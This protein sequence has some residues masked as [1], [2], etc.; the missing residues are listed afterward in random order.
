MNDADRAMIARLDSASPAEIL[1]NPELQEQVHALLRS[2]NERMQEA[3]RQLGIYRD[4]LAR[5][6]VAR[7]I[8]SR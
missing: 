8:D 3:T 2:L 6:R 1:A 5:S 7:Q 4:F